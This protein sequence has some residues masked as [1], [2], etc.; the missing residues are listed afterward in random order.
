MTLLYSTLSAGKDVKKGNVRL[1]DCWVFVWQ[2]LPKAVIP[3]S[4]CTVE[5]P[6]EV[7]KHLHPNPAP[8]I[9]IQLS[10][11]GAKGPEF[12]NVPRDSNMQPRLRTNN[13]R[14]LLRVFWSEPWSIPIFT[15]CATK[16]KRFQT[17]WAGSPVTSRGYSQLSHSY[18][19]NVEPWE[20]VDWTKGGKNN[21]GK[22]LALV[23]LF[24][25]QGILLRHPSKDVGLT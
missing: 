14:N 23:M 20:R 15:G 2:K 17:K 5:S 4:H 13:V 9:L 1:L 25:V 21:R 11:V 3:N 19:S 8:G 18:S 16:M 7:L 22:R 10:W 6:E 12:L 24:L